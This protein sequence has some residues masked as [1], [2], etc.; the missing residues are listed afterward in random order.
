MVRRKNDP[1]SSGNVLF[2]V[3]RKSTGLYFKPEYRDPKWEQNGR[4]YPTLNGAL[5]AADNAAERTATGGTQLVDVNDL[6]VV[7][8]HVT[9]ATTHAPRPR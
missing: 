5:T 2:K 9:E 1:G 6:E 7:E 3:R 4:A 8:F